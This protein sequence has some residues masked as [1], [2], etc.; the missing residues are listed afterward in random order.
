LNWG[1]QRNF[2]LSATPFGN[3]GIVAS[4]A[5]FN[6]KSRQRHDHRN[7]H[8]PAAQERKKNPVGIDP[9]FAKFFSESGTGPHSHA[10]Y[11]KSREIHSEVSPAHDRRILP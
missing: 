11:L 7:P 10:V 5:V 3:D 6:P 1:K 4:A 9:P 8:A 2:S